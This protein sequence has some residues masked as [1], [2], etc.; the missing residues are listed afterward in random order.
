MRY[1]RRTAR[2]TP[3]SLPTISTGCPTT[4]TTL[5][6]AGGMAP[7][8]VQGRMRDDPKRLAH[9]QAVFEDWIETGVATVAGYLVD[10]PRRSRAIRGTGSR[11]PTELK[12]AVCPENSLT[13][14]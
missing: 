2:V 8:V 13:H 14:S 11:A 5:G 6:C 7:E 9:W 12:M 1:L 3:A 4:T 10:V